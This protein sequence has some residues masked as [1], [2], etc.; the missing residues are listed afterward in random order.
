M[1]AMTQSYSPFGLLTESVPAGEGGP[2][3]EG[4]PYGE[5]GYGES[6]GYEAPPT[7]QSPFGAV[8][9]RELGAGEAEEWHEAAYELLAELEDEDFTDAL[10]ALVDEA[11]ARHTLDLVSW[12]SPP[13]PA[14]SRSLLE[15]WIQPLAGEAERSLDSL[16]ELLAGVDAATVSPSHLNEL[17]DSVGEVPAM[18]NEVFEQFIGGLIKKAKSLVGGAVKLVKK[19]VQAVGKVLPIGMIL[20]RLKGLVQNLLKGVLQKAIGKLPAGLQPIAR[21]VAVK[22]GIAAPTPAATSAAGVAGAG[23]A[24]PAAASA[25][26]APAAPGGAD[27][28][29]AAADPPEGEDGESPVM[30]AEAFDAQLVGLLPAAAG[31][32]PDQ[33]DREGFA[34]SGGLAEYEDRE[35]E[36]REGDRQ[37]QA[38]RELDDARAR[39]AEQLVELPAGE[40]AAPAVQQFLPVLLAAKPLIKMAIGFIGRDKIINFVAGRIASLIGGLVGADAARQLSRPLVDIGLRALGFEAP[41]QPESLAGEALAATV[42]GTVERLLELPAEA[43]ADQL[44]LDSALQTAFAEAA[45]AAIPDRFLRSDMPEREVSGS[46]GVWVMLPRAARPH[47]RYRGYSR[48]FVVPLS[49]QVARTVPWSDG[50]TLESYL[51]DRGVRTWPAPAEIRLYETLPGTQL[52]HVVQGEASSETSTVAEQAQELQPLTPE[53]AGLLVGEP[54]L[55][56]RGR[57][58]AAAPGGPAMAGG[59]QAAPGAGRRFFAVR[60]VGAGPARRHGRRPRRRL[61]VSFALAGD[62]PQVRVTLRLTERQGQELAEK[63]SPSG[64]GKQ[65]DLAGVLAVLREHYGTRL[66]ALVTERLTRLALVADAAQAKAVSERLVAAATTALSTSLKE[67]PHLIAAAVREPLQGIMITIT[68]PGVTKESL[69][70]ELP[71]GVVAVSAGWRR[72]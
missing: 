56:R 50:G 20:N 70:K 34:E 3:G 24:A 37:A 44:Q 62:S 55:G 52:G 33:Q 14:E 67:R 47:Y 59:A 13:S 32:A 12:S 11:A 27:G 4:G 5:G 72:R 66:P 38:Y 71:A 54:G 17:L 53:I 1:T 23:A 29:A 42:E 16:A 60:P 48:V 35:Y 61:G 31:L 21:T 18:G 30:L 41:A 46:G 7:L 45:A 10:E 63:L 25:A 19:G 68:F 64:P 65:P 51:L 49:R 40:S 22:L 28:G 43:F 15:A 6:G 2:H 39:L 58:G 36:D 26:G 8:A 57:P 69:T 9:V